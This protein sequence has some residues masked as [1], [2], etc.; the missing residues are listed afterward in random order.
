MKTGNIVSDNINSFAHLKAGTAIKPPLKFETGI[1]L[2]TP[3]TGALEFH[4]NKLHIT[5]KS[6]RKAID[7]T[8]DIVLETVTV[9][10]TAVET[11]MWTG[12]M[13]ANSLV[14]GNM[15]KF[16]ADG[17]VSNDGSASPDDQITLRIKVGGVE[18]VILTPATKALSG[19]HWHLKANACQRT[20]GG[21][22]SRAIHIDLSIDDISVVVVGVAN[23]DTTIN[24]DVTVTAQWGTAKATNTISLYQGFMEYKN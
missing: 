13:P 14:A 11:T 18:K 9:A 6:V 17:I 3:E 5:N 12:L 15:F 10:N 22:G 1:A 23:I 19:D 20:I 2:T 7:R 8:S 4:N 24:M 21:S 16:H